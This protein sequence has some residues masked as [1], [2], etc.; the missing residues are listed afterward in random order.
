VEGNRGLANRVPARLSSREG[1]RFGLTVGGAFLLLALIAWWRGRSMPAGVFAALGLGLTVAGL[2]LPTRLGPIER[3]WMAGGRAISRV[4]TPVMVSVVYIFVITPM[5]LAMRAL[6][7]N[8]L[9]Q[10]EQAAGS[11]VE[12][13]SESETPARMER[14][15]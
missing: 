5:G 7:K 4:T 11:W 1:R 3:A 13:S 9:K 15:F 14:Q 12:R 6:G 2:I 10:R 8:P